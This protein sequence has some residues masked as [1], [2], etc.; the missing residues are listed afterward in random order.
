VLIYLEQRGI[1]FGLQKIGCGSNYADRSL[2]I[3]SPE[4]FKLCTTRENTLAWQLCRR[5][6][7]RLWN[8]KP[9]AKGG[10]K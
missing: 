4:I 3:A 5:V 2:F 8:N 7:M 1:S 10:M 9:V 6:F